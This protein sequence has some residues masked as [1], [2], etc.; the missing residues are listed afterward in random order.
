[1]GGSGVFLANRIF[2]VCIACGLTAQCIKVVGTYLRERRIN[3]KQFVEMGGMPSAHSAAVAALAVTVG[4]ESGFSSALFA[5]TLVLS[6]MVMYDAAGLRGSVGRQAELLNRILDDFYAT[7]RIPERN[8]RELIGHTPIEVIAGAIL[9]IV[10][11]LAMY[12]GT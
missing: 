11:A 9:G 7:K 6:L 8:L 1:M 12:P 4:L 10:F 5:V 2:W 3:F